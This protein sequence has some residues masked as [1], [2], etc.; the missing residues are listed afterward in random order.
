MA[1]PAKTFK[2]LV[3]W[4]KAHRFVLATYS[5]TSSFPKSE[6]YCLTIQMRGAAISRWKRFW[7]RSP[8]YWLPTREQSSPT[9]KPR[10]N[11]Q[12][13]PPELLPYPPDSKKRPSCAISKDSIATALW[14]AFND[15]PTHFVGIP[16][17]NF[18]TIA[19]VLDSSIRTISPSL[20]VPLPKTKALCQVQRSSSVG[21]TPCLSVMFPKLA[22]VGN[23]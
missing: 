20:L 6:I 15:G 21:M 14:V 9:A 11:H 7:K 23:L 22:R 2:E 3:V 19:G 10:I 13:L 12:L 4:Q 5:L 8:C 18:Q 16:R 17:I 1:K